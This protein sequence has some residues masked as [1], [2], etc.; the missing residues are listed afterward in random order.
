MFKI[1]WKADKSTWGDLIAHISVDGPP[2]LISFLGTLHNPSQAAKSV[3]S[4]LHL[5]YD[6]GHIKIWA[7]MLLIGD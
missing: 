3:Y 1:V 5:F 6:C 2:S 4:S 7:H